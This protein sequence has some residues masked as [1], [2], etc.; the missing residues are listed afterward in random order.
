RTF[1]T[2]P[3]TWSLVVLG[4]ATGAASRLPLAACLLGLALLTKETALLLIVPVL[5]A[6]W[7]L[8]GLRRAAVLAA[9]PLLFGVLFVVKNLRTV[10]EPLATFQPWKLGQPATGA[11]GLLIEPTRG[12][13]WFAPVLLAAAVVGWRNPDGRGQAPPLHPRD[14]ASGPAPGQRR[15]AVDLAVA[16]AFVGYYALTAAWVEWRGGEGFG[17]RLLVPALPGLALPLAYLLRR[18]R[19]PLGR[20]VVGGLAVV[21]FTVGWCAALYPV[22]AFWQSLGAALLE[23]SPW[24]TVSGLLGGTALATALLRA[25]APTPV[26]VPAVQPAADDRY[27]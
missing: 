18:L 1:F 2:E 4:L 6:A 22:A 7:R 19:S 20:G 16:A 13:V 17:P 27:L 5:L 25:T 23:A 8:L 9:G 24:A 21:G 12:L 14:H 10:G 3:Y 11:L 26:A 15:L